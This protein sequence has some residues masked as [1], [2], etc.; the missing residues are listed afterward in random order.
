MAL[1]QLSSVRRSAAPTD[2]VTLI[3]YAPYGTDLALTG[4]PG[5]SETDV[6]AH[7]LLRNLAR[8]AACGV[9]VYA[10]VDLVDRTTCMVEFSANRST[11]RI[12]TRWKQRMEAREPLQGLISYACER[13]PGTMLVLG[14][15]GHGAGYLP[16]LDLNVL[17]AEQVTNHGEFEWHMGQESSAPVL[18]MGSP[19]LPMGS[20]VLPMGSPV[21][22]ATGMPLSTWALGQAIR[23]GLSRQTNPLGVVLLNSCFN[24]SVEVLHTIAPLAEFAGGFANYN[25][26]TAGESYALAFEALKAS[27]GRATTKALAVALVQANGR[28]L[29]ARSH[30]PT[31]GAVVPL[32]RMPQIASRLDALAR[33]LIRAMTAA[34]DPR[35]HVEVSLKIREAIRGAQQYD[36]HT[37][38]RLDAPDELTDL[39][40]L[41]HALAD[42]PDNAQE[43]RPAAAALARSLQGLK[44]Y[45]NS[46]SPW[47]APNVT[48]DFS[49]DDLSMNIFLPDPGLRGL[50]DWRAPFY[51]QPRAEEAEVR[52]QPHVIDFL[53]KTAWVD[54]IIEY[55]RHQPFKGLR[56]ARIPASVRFN[57]QHGLD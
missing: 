51:L 30:H 14:L 44:V 55:H 26:F 34:G 31:M 49:R 48:W 33:A 53:K 11:P 38:L 8:V 54:F 2:G 24:M 23:T 6:P 17:T 19:V 50:W 40:T 21:L 35:H 27:G 39:G 52:V 16:E 7:P 20:P 10:L 45:G 18:P 3:V 57:A 32:G 15:E 46:G 28:I 4:Y 22:P 56:P 43:V 1:A 12:T 9:H 37:P 29:Q 47:M 36:T 25:F 13:R 42:F 41:A 5:T